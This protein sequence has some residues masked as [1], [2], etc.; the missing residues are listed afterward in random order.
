MSL[1]LSQLFLTLCCSSK[2]PSNQSLTTRPISRPIDM[3]IARSITPLPL[4]NLSIPFYLFLPSN[5]RGVANYLRTPKVTNSQI[6]GFRAYLDN[7]IN[8][9]NGFIC[10]SLKE[11]DQQ[12]VEEFY[13]LSGKQ[14][15]IH[16]IG[17]LVFDSQ[18][19]NRTKVSK[20]EVY[21]NKFII[22]EILD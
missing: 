19:S 11:F 2:F 12:Y 20:I 17:P 4:L 15:P 5:L 6:K 10:N 22:F 13:Q 21:Q 9:A 3:I 1:A 14:V 8:Q 18:M 7:N 16:F